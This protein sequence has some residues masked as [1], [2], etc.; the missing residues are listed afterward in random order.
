MTFGIQ[1]MIHFISNESTNY[2]LN[3]EIL[4][5]GENASIDFLQRTAIKLV[6][7]LDQQS[8]NYMEIFSIRSYVSSK[9]NQIL[10]FERLEQII[11]ILC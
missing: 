8:E 2:F 10:P 11:D 4:R 3:W 6:I 9:K 7:Q 5:S 1:L